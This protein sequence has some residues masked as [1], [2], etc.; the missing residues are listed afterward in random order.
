MCVCT[1]VS[2]RVSLSLSACVAKT[3]HLPHVRTP[4]GWPTHGQQGVAAYLQCSS[5]ERDHNPGARGWTLAHL[6][7]E[8][9][10]RWTLVAR[11]SPTHTVNSQSKEN[12]IAS[13]VAFVCFA[14][15]SIVLFIPSFLLF[16]LHPLLLTPAPALFCPLFPSNSQVSH[17]PQATRTCPP[18]KLTV[19][20]SSSSTP[21]SSGSS[22]SFSSS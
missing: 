17:I 19:S 14:N 21:G 10:D 11:Q 8:V 1:C 3:L 7:L 6:R 18:P 4:T 5:S 13:A 9:L 15:L 22:S 16:S 2:L 12:V 20:T